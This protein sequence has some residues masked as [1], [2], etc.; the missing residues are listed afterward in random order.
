[1]THKEHSSQTTAVVEANDFRAP[2]LESEKELAEFP[3]RLEGLPKKYREEILRQ[4]EIPTSKA[5]L[6]TILGSAT[7]MEV[8]LMIF[9]TILSITAG[10]GPIG[11]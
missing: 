3:K 7:W 2:E 10:I 8:L 11:R 6:L 1:M 4:Y 9:A 5:T